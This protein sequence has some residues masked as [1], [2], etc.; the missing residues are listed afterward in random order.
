[1]NEIFGIPRLLR[2]GVF[3]IAC[4]AAL[5]LGAKCQAAESPGDWSVRA[6]L[7]AEQ[8]E[9]PTDRAFRA[10]VLTTVP[11]T[12]ATQRLPAV[13]FIPWLSCDPVEVQGSTDDGYIRFVRDISAQ[14][15]MVVSRVEK[16]GVAES[17]GPDCSVSTLDDDFAAIRAGLVAVRARPDVDTTKVFLV[18]GSIGG[19]FAVTLAA[20]S[21]SRLEQ[22]C[23]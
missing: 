15:Q 6:G 1:M 5:P 21:S 19:A 20:E 8:T 18:G 3:A 23:R 12:M 17:E 16:P 14:S 7:T 9:V 2:L 13:L 22:S 11:S 4:G 10:R